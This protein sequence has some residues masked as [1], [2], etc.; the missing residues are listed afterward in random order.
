VRALQMSALA[1]AVALALGGCS[2]QPPPMQPVPPCIDLKGAP[3]MV[4]PDVSHPASWVPDREDVRMHRRAK[5][6]KRP[7]RHVDAR[8]AAASAKPAAPQ[9]VPTVVE[10]SAPQAVTSPPS[11]EQPETRAASN[12]PAA[13]VGGATVQEQVAVAT[14]LAER[15]TALSALPVPIARQSNKEQQDTTA[16]REAAAPTRL[17]AVLMVRP[18]VRAIPELRGRVIAIDE[19]YILVHDKVTAAIAAAGASEVQ[20]MQG[21]GTA[22]NRLTNGEVAAAVVALVVPEAADAFPEIA[23]FRIFRVP[24]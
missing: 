14:A 19:R 3:C 6:H 4:Q 17:V 9:P 13:R 12:A 18:G 20:L 11:F 7:H 10:A 22:I 23:G 1:A 15:I 5:R 24:L 8:H 2:R 21:Q 16:P